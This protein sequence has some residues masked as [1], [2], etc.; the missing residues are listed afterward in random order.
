MAGH[1]NHLP[2]LAHT[3]SPGPSPDIAEN[4]HIYRNTHYLLRE[5]KEWSLTIFGGL[6]FKI[7]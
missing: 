2:N 5:F 6:F 4:T 1:G 3:R 7:N